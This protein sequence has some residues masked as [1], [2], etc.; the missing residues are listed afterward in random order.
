M[1]KASKWIRNHV[2]GKKEERSCIDNNID[3]SPRVERRWSF[4]RKPS[5]S[6]TGNIATRRLS[7]SFDSS[8]TANLHMPSFVHT[9]APYSFSTSLLPKAPRDVQSA[10]AAKIQAA[11]RS[12]LARK[13]L[14]ALKGLV[15]I[16]ALVRGHLVRKQTSATLR[17]MHALMAI[18]VRARIQR[19]QAAQEASLLLTKYSSRH[20]RDK[21]LL[22]E[23]KAS[24]DMDLQEMLEITE[25]RSGPLDP[26]DKEH[27]VMSCYSKQKYQ[28]EDNAFTA[29]QGNNLSRSQRHSMS[30][31]AN[32]LT[33][34]ES[35][36]AK[37]G[38]CSELKQRPL[39]GT[40]RKSKAIESMN[41]LI[42]SLDGRRQSVSS[43]SSRFI[44]HG[45]LDHW[46]MNHYESSADSKS[47]S[48]NSSI[49]MTTNDSDY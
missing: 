27:V 8:H 45:N 22:K 25:S 37:A 44:Y 15:K 39:Q 19:L 28:Y 20:P 5:A 21:H 3:E 18:Q 38:S 49:G 14:H 29:E 7:A 33:R 32:D 11:F 16:Q 6:M 30:W 42:F 35:S 48:F 24:K 1:K 40:S 10:A 4:G 23:S 17:G 9:E 43:N 31:A 36:R 2:M 13:A 26:S 12:Y 47:E 34:T 41:D 46:V